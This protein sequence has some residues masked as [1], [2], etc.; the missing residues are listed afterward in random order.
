MPITHLCFA[1]LFPFPIRTGLTT[2]LWENKYGGAVDRQPIAAHALTHTHL[3]LRAIMG[4]ENAHS[5][6]AIG[7]SKNGIA[8]HDP[9]S[10]SCDTGRHTMQS[11]IQA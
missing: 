3:L 9:G 10:P 8:L 1:L 7:S 5:A 6:Q 4:H 11:I 2:A